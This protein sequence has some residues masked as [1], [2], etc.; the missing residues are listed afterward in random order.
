[1]VTR[2]LLLFVSMFVLVNLCIMTGCYISG[3]NLYKKNGK[4]ILMAFSLF[5]LL[6]AV[7]YV[8]VAFLGLE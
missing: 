7:L 6:I 4:Q 3:E 1:M 2:V 5:A 8:A